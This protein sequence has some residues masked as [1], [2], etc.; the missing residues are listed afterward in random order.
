VKYKGR[1][2][3]GKE[4]ASGN[5]FTHFVT[6][7]LANVPEI[8]EAY[9]MWREDII[10]KNYPE[11]PERLLIKPELLH[12]TLLIMDLSEA[13]MLERARETMRAI[14]PQI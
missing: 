2:F 5:G 4:G 13:G 11:F 1:K 14:E 6:L 9:K 8:R 10:A 12:I 3:K 7:P